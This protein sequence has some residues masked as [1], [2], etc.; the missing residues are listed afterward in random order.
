MNERLDRINATREREGGRTSLGPLADSFDIDIAGCTFQPTYPQNIYDLEALNLDA[1]AMGEN[2]TAVLQ[3]EPDNTYD[4]NAIA[5]HCP[6][7]GDDG[8]IGHVP[9]HLAARLAPHLDAGEQWLGHV[10]YIR[11]NH[12]H[13]DKPG[14]TIN[15]RKVQ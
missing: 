1:E 9:R 11:F 3:R 5:V 14:I 7:L 13:P 2:L 6:A 15:V 4:A 10:S 12:D 8:Q